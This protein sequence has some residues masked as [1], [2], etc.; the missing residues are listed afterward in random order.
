MCPSSLN[1][2]R[3]DKDCGQRLAL[4]V[5][6]VRGSE[7][8]KMSAIP[9]SAPAR[10]I[11]ARVSPA[12]SPCVM[13]SWW[14]PAYSGTYSAGCR[15]RAALRA[16]ASLTSIMVIDTALDRVSVPARIVRFS[17]SSTGSEIASAPLV[18]VVPAVPAEICGPLLIL[19]V[20]ELRAMLHL[21]R[22]ARSPRSRQGALASPR[23]RGPPVSSPA[24]Q[25]GRLQLE[26][27]VPP[28]DL[29]ARID[30]VDAS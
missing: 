10:Y 27:H 26:E 25:P 20:H 18:A 14:P 17:T 2:P 6:T 9:C 4:L 19:R 5:R 11:W 23:R 1:R 12:D 24:P 8:S 13:R 21:R 3:I 7:P 29:E 16:F 15:A 30:E 28:D 22:N